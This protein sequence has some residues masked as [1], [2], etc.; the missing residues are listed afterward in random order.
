MVLNNAQNAV[1]EATT[2]FIFDDITSEEL[3]PTQINA[4]IS[5]LESPDF[6]ANEPHMNI[7]SRQRDILSN[8]IGS[9]DQ[10]KE[11]IEHPHVQNRSVGSPYIDIPHNEEGVFIYFY[12]G[13]HIP[14]KER[15]GLLGLSARNEEGARKAEN[16]LP[17]GSTALY[18]RKCSD[19]A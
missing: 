13:D 16:L 1:L 12:V 2:N 6:D 5:I 17:D 10:L 4:V 18:G 8:I 19:K 15:Q 11:I 3:T 14:V 9:I 7:S